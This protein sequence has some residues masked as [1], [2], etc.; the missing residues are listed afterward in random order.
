MLKATPREAAVRTYR[1]AAAGLA[2]LVIAMGLSTAAA[3]PALAAAATPRAAGKGSFCAL[4]PGL[5]LHCY[6]QRSDFAARA[7]QL[8]STTASCPVFL[9]TAANYGGRTLG[10]Y[11]E[12][13]WLNLAQYGFDNATVSFVGNGCGFHL[14]DYTWGGGAWY[15][16]NTGA[17][18]Y[19]A[20]MGSAWSGRVSSVYV[21]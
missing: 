17:W 19:C 21:N 15:P 8:S 12:G 18:S 9:Y 11:V 20:N 2:V 10:I 16:G 14:A 1:A 5:T 4:E 7:S 13:Q 3:R 6:A